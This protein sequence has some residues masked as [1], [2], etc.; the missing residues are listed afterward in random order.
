MCAAGKGLRLIER[1]REGGG[2]RERE[3]GG[4]RV[5]EKER[6]EGGHE[7]QLLHTALSVLL[8]VHILLSSLLSMPLLS[9]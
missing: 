6:G 7:A 9:Q 1:E 2:E 5:R 8:R 3:G 4:E